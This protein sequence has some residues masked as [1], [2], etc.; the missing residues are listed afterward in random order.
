VPANAPEALE[1]RLLEGRWRAELGD[2]GG[3]SVALGR[4]RAAVELK[5][6]GGATPGAEEAKKVAALLVEAAQIEERERGDPLAAQ[7]HLGLAI[8][9]LPRNREIAGEFRRIAGE[10]ARGAPRVEPAAEE[11]APR[12]PAPEAAPGSAA[13]GSA[14]TAVGAD[15]GAE[16]VEDE[17]LVER[18]TEKLRADPTDHRTALALAG[19]LARLGRNLDLLALLSARM[20]EG[21]DEVRRELLPLRR[22]VLMRLSEEAREAGRAS[23]A[24]LYEM[25]LSGE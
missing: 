8:R 9:L 16:D 25:M 10:L 23:E 14:L 24:E 17:I 22:E 13:E 15:A 6:S 1:A 20:E 5:L 7:R 12:E 11:A 2:A 3:A 4:L 19:A 18:L 21:G